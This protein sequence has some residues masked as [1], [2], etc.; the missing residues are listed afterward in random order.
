[1]RTILL[2]AILAGGLLVRPAPVQATDINECNDTVSQ[3]LLDYV[4]GAVTRWELWDC[5]VRYIDC[6]VDALKAY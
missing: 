2:A 6:V 1:M 4:I 3:C 5:E